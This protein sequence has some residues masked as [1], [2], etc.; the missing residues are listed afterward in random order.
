MVNKDHQT[1]CDQLTQMVGPEIHAIT[2][3][4]GR[5]IGVDLPIN[6]WAKMQRYPHTSLMGRGERKTL[7]YSQIVRKDPYFSWINP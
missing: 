1:Q 6:H 5:D 2:S 3:R 4:M 7:R